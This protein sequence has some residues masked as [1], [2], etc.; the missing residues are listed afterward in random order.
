MHDENVAT[1]I[2]HVPVDAEQ[3]L[4]IRC[5]HTQVVEFPCGWLSRVSL[6]E[7]CTVS[8]GKLNG[9]ISLEI[10]AK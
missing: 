8:L 1:L 10:E 4:A 6:Y 3:I 7:I 9:P 5:G 2:A